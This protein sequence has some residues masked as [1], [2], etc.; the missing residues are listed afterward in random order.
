[1]PFIVSSHS[2]PFLFSESFCSVTLHRNFGAESLTWK[3]NFQ[4]FR[5]KNKSVSKKQTT[6]NKQKMQPKP[7][8]QGIWMVFVF[9]ALWEQTKKLSL[10]YEIL[11]DEN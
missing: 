7:S 2:F 1:M 6:T 9:A 8:T 5:L 3:E 4:V 11:T 10:L